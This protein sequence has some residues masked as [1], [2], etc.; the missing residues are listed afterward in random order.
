MKAS[1]LKSIRRLSATTRSMFALGLVICL[2]LAVGIGYWPGAAWATPGLMF[3]SETLARSLFDNIDVKSNSDLL[4]VKIE[5]KGSADVYI[6]RNTV[7]PGGYSGW[8]THPGPSIVSVKSGTATVY[9]G[10]D[11]NCTPHTYVAGTGFIDQGD[12]HVHMVRNEGTVDLIVVAFQIIPAG[13][14]RRIDAAS[15]GYCPF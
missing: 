7:P 15:P 6:V 12:G 5:T 3:N 10:N 8:H 14:D 9:D 1:I 11:P 13:A 4:K 2:S